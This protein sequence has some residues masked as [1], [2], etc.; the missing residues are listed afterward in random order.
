[1]LQQR[2]CI[3]IIYIIFIG[4]ADLLVVNEPLHHTDNFTMKKKTTH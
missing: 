3:F 4:E 2:A 1:M